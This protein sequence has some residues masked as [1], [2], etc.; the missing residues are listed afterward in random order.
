M[1][2]FSFLI[3][4]LNINNIHAQF[5][6]GGHQDS[7]GCLIDGGYKWCESSQSCIRPWITTC[8]DNNI[9][10]T[11]D[12]KD[13]LL[14]NN[15]ITVNNNNDKT[16]N[17]EYCPDSSIQMCRMICPKPLCNVNQCAERKGTCCE[18]QCKNNNRILGSGNI[19]I[20]CISW[21]DGCNTCS[22]LNGKINMCTMKYCLT[23][24]KG[25]CKAY[26]KGHR[27]LL[28]NVSDKNN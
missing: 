25:H 7:K 28:K 27:R 9:I 12:N 20:N 23:S 6:M 10:N 24:D 11:G 14:N 2:L 4:I 5:L 21:F 13:T 26:S 22:V 17:T 19:P 3:N 16:V 1:K 8:L 18:Y 15:D